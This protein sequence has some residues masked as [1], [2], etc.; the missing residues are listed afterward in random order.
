MGSAPDCELVVTHPSISRRHLSVSVES[1]QLVVEDLGS[2]N[3]TRV[4]GIRISEP[5]PVGI[6][7]TIQIGTL[8]TWFEAV[9]VEDIEVARELPRPLPQAPPLGAPQAT[10]ALGSLRRFALELV[11]RMVDLL[12]ERAAPEDLARALGSEL[13]ELLAP[14]RLEICRAGL[15]G[16]S[17]VFRAGE[18]GPPDGRLV[19]L[20]AGGFDVCIDLGGTARED[21]LTPL[22]AVGARFLELAVGRTPQPAGRPGAARVAGAVPPLPEPPTVDPDVIRLYRDAARIARGEVSVLILG[23]SGTGKEVLATYLHRASGRRDGPLV[24]LNCAA[25][26]RDLLE[27]ELFGIERGVATGVQPRAGKFELASGGTLFLDEIGDMALETQAKIL[28]VLQQGQVYRV[29]SSSPQPA[30]VRIVAATNRDLDGMVEAGTFRLDLYH[31][32][33]DWVV[34][35][36]SLRDRPADI[37]NLAAFFLEREARRQGVAIVG[38]S[39]GALAALQAAPWP[40]NIRQ[41]EREMARAAL[42][43]EDGELLERSHLSATVVAASSRPATLRERL[44]ECERREL[45]AAVRRHGGDVS[46]AAIELGVGRSTLYRRLHELGVA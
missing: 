31:R 41:L 45:E 30:D 4:A 6:G 46:A 28:R 27:A 14:R 8:E 7:T 26:P 15:G 40:G 22:A 20:P 11:P 16:E 23:D 17:L 42:F 1:A 24:A 25:L 32:V 21:A 3:G 44:A 18:E 5:C 2:R 10:V 9:A 36:P 33:A 34:S 12:G 38:I 39:R 19:R 43:L 37:A 35:L 13:M 29:G